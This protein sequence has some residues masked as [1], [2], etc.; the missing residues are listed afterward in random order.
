MRE[1]LT[2][3]E[4]LRVKK[5]NPFTCYTTNEKWYNYFRYRSFRNSQGEPCGFVC[6]EEQTSK[7]GPA[8]FVL[9]TTVW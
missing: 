5:D 8:V 3:I 6:T 7:Y 9:T 2:G 4:K 1:F